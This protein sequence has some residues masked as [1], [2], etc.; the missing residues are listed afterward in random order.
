M[1]SGGDKGRTGAVVPCCQTL[2]PPNEKKSVT[3]SSKKIVT[4]KNKNILSKRNVVKKRKITIK[5]DQD[6]KPNKEI[7]K[8]LKSNDIEGNDEKEGW[9]N[10]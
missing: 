8:K 6:I 2:G 1:R 3:S 7:S 9:W 10:R 4:K 5:N